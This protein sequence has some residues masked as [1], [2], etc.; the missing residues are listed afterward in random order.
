[1]PPTA[2]MLH[3]ETTACPPLVLC[4]SGH[5]PS[6]GAG[7]QADIET[8]AACGALCQTIPSC[9]TVQNH[10]RVTAC[11]PVADD[12]FGQ[13]LATLTDTQS[14]QAVKIGLLG[15]AGQVMQIVQW[16]G[17]M[18]AEMPVVLD[19]VIY[20]SDGF[21]L[22]GQSL[23]QAIHRHLLPRVTLLTP[24]HAEARILGE[25]EDLDVAVDCLLKRGCRQILLTGGDAEGDTVSNQLHARTGLI[26]RWQHPRLPQAFHGSGCTLASAAASYLAQ[27]M[28]IE[29]ACAR[30]QAFTQ[31]ALACAMALDE[32]PRLPRRRP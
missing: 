9:L 4:I 17:R 26:K 12:L 11:Y 8:V 22:G 3:P 28:D 7:L 13:M 27:G 10:R 6:G 15:S 29:T 25:C 20:A 24:N 32:G 14:F 16:L 18:P 30:A 5:D 21:A 19:P 23:I 1:M 2:V 31:S